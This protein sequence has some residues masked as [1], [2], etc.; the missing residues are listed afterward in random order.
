MKPKL[1][2]TIS[3]I[4]MGLVGLGYLLAPSTMLVSNVL[5]SAQGGILDATLN[6][7]LRGLASNFFGFAVLN[8]VARNTEASK[9][10]EAIFISNTVGFGLAAVLNGVAAMSVGLAAGWVVAGINLLFAIVFFFTGRQNTS[11]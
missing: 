3:A 1:L 2:L 10:R 9:A 7:G 4:Y 8:W 5:S 11:S 6:T